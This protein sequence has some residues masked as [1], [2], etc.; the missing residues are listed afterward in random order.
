MIEMILRLKGKHYALF[1]A[2]L[3]FLSLVALVWLVLLDDTRF[4]DGE[5]LLAAV[6]FM[7]MGVGSGSIAAADEGKKQ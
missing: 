4:A 5:V 3:S 1:L 6:A 2:F 7:L